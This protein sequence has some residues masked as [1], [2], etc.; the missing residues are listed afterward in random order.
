MALW[1][2][3]LPTA[4]MWGV[5]YPLQ[6]HLAAGR[7]G[8]GASQDPPAPSDEADTGPFSAALPG[9]RPFQRCRPFLLQL[10][11]KRGGQ[12]RSQHRFSRALCDCDLCFTL[13][14]AVQFITL[15]LMGFPGGSAGKEP[16]CPC[17]RCKSCG[18]NSWVGKVPWR[19]KWQPTLVFLPGES[20]GPRG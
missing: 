13:L 14:L 7:A 12:C 9:P 5:S 20:H 18:F 4:G 2:S 15:K 10:L 19:R 8:A 6:A 3:L 17:R 11:P 16:T 1:A